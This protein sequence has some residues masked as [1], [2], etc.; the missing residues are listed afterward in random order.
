MGYNRPGKKDI[1]K[2]I[3]DKLQ[4]MERFGVSKYADKKAGI[5]KS[6]IYSYNTAKAYHRDCQRFAEY[7]KEHSPHGRHTS[8]ED[9]RGYAKEY[10]QSLNADKSVSA[11][12]VKAR[13]AALAKLYE[14]TSKE[15]GA[16]E[17]RHRADITRSRNRTVV[18]D[19][20]GKVILNQQTNAGHFSEKKHAEIVEFCKAT[21]L[22]R[23]ELE[24]LQGHQLKQIKGKYYVEVAGKGGKVRLAPIIGSHTQEVVDRCLSHLEE[25]VWEKVPARMDVHHYRS[26]YATE[27]YKMLARERGDIPREDRYCCRKDLKGVWYDKVAMKEVSEALGH[28]RISVIAEHYLR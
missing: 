17:S 18:S 23:C 27:M 26:Q 28:N 21:G 20:T 25:K 19:K 3:K 10:I 14:C 8:L 5:T 2:E 4:A 12:T 6:G 16:T 9:A 1:H 7:V 15:F 24:K 22:R 13:A 11:Y